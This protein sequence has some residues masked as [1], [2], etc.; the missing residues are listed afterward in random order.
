MFFCYYYYW[1]LKAYLWS[2]F[3]HSHFLNSGSFQCSPI[4][5]LLYWLIYMVCILLIVPFSITSVRHWCPHPL[6]PD[7]PLPGWNNVKCVRNK[8]K[9]WWRDSDAACWLFS[10]LPPA[11]AI[12]RQAIIQSVC[13]AAPHPSRNRPA[14]APQSR[15]TR[16]NCCGF[17]SID[18]SHLSSQN[19]L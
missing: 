9:R 12:D 2:N 3:N 7:L 14:A 10:R 8:E 4:L 17:L 1:E 19:H 5:L 11:P 18:C 13:N 15:E 16:T 6:R